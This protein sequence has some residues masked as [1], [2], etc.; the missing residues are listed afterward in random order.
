MVQE[1]DCSWGKDRRSSGSLEHQM[2]Q[3]ADQQEYERAARYRDQ[4]DALQRAAEDQRV[5]SSRGEDQDLFGVAQ[6]GR[7]AQVQLLVV[8]AAG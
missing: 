1:F 6:E 4:I 7:E 3:A 2:R 8:R 5:I